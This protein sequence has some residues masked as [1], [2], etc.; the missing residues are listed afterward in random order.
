MNTANKQRQF[1][2]LIV[3]SNEI[4]IDIYILAQ[5]TRAGNNMSL[6][7]CSFKSKKFNY[8]AYACDI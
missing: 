4:N 5:R 8:S 6:E 2:A 7:K 3:V 1:T